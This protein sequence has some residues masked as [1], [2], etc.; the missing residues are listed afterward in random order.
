LSLM[1]PATTLII[2]HRLSSLLD[3]DRILVLEEGKIVADGSPAELAAENA[4]FRS[5][6]EGGRGP[7]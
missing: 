7:E 4:R 6:L 3:V 5:M 1:E 2:A